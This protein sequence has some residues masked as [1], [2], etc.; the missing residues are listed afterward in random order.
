MNSD[1]GTNVRTT[2]GAGKQQIGVGFPRRCAAPSGYELRRRPRRQLAAARMLPRVQQ[3]A[4]LALLLR[5]GRRC[6]A[7]H[8]AL[9]A[10]Q[11]RRRG[12]WPQRRHPAGGQQAVQRDGDGGQAVDPGGGGLP[13][14]PRAEVGGEVVAVHLQ[15]VVPAGRRGAGRGVGA[16]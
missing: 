5:H 10:S 8:L 16:G 15:Q 7:V 6:Q 1:W 9:V 4:A 2:E 12:G 3:P 11:Q 14:Q 13:R